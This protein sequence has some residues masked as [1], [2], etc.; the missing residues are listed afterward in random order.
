MKLKLLFL[1]SIVFLFINMIH[2]QNP[3]TAIAKN[4]TVKLDASGN[5]TVNAQDV[6]NG[7]TD[8]TGIASY[9]LTTATVGTRCITA[10]ENS[11]L[12]AAAATGSIFKTVDFAIYG[13]SAK[14]CADASYPSCYSNV[15]SFVSSYFLNNNSASIFISNANM[16]GDPCPNVGKILSISASYEPSPAS[17]KPSF[18]FSC[19]NIGDNTVTLV[20][21]DTDGNKSYATATIKVIDDTAPVITCPANIVTNSDPGICTANVVIPKAG[22]L[23][24]KILLIAA[25]NVSWVA[26]VQNKLI[27]TGAFDSVDFFNAASGTPGTTLLANYKAALVWT[28]NVLNNATLLGNNLATYVDNG[29][30]VVSMVFELSGLGVSGAFNTDAYRCLIA[31]GQLNGRSQSLGTVYNSMHPIMNGVLSFNG[32]TSGYRSSSRTLATGAVKIADWADGTPL[33]IIKENVGLSKVRRADLNFFPPSS[34]SRSDFWTATTDGTILMKNA[35]LWVVGSAN[36]IAS[37]NCSNGI[38]V[39]NNITGTNDASGVYPVGITEV[40]WKATDASGNSVQCTQTVEVKDNQ[41]PVVTS[42]GDQNVNVDANTCG[43]TVTVSA[44]ATDNCSVGNPTGVRSD[45]KLLTDVYPVGTTTIKWN[46]KDVN[47]NDAVELIQAVTV[48]DNEIPVIVSNGDQNVNTDSGICG[49]LVSVSATATDNCAVVTPTGVR[50]DSKLLTDFY[51][52]GS[53]TIT[54]NVS[55]DNGNAAAVVIQTV[56]VTDNELPTVIV[57][58][59]TAQLDA[60]GNATILTSDV[61]NGSSDNCGI[62]KIELDKTSFTCA[63][64]GANTVTLTVTDV[65]GNVS[66]QTAI[67]TIEDK[68]A[69][70]VLTKD[71]TVQLD[72]TG[73]ASIVTSDIDNGST[74]ACGIATLVVS[75]NAFTCANLG[76]NTVTLTATDTNGNISSQTAIVTI[77]DKIAA[78]VLTKDITVQLDATGN[79]SVVTSDIDNGSTDA[80]GIATLVVSPNAFTCANLG[81]NTVTLTATDA[82]GNISSQT[83]IVTIEDK[84]A[85]TVLTK[86][87]T[88]QLDATGNASIVTSDIDNGSTDACGIAI[89]VVSPNAFTCANLG[90]NT[91]T[92]TATDVNGNISSQTAIV[93]IEDKI[94]PTVLTKDITVQLDASGVVTIQAADVDNGS[95]DICGAPTLV[96]S[97][98]TFTCANIGNNTVTLTATD[99]SGNTSSKT[100]IVKVENKILPNVVT[101]NI[102]IQLNASGN[103]SLVATDINNGSTYA[104]GTPTLI[105][106]PNTFTCANIG[107]NIVTLT[108][109]DAYGNVSS[110]TATVIIEDKIAP[111][112][113]AKNITVQ[114]DATGSVTIIPAQVDN[115][116]TDI[117]NAPILSLSKSTFT[118]NNVGANTI[119]LTAIDA[120]GNKSSA[121][122]ILTVQDNILP[123]AKT[124]DLTVE[125]DD[126]GNVSITPNQINNGSSDNCGIAT[127]TLDKLS[128]NCTNVGVNTVILTVKDKAGNTATATAKVTIVN[129]AGDNDNDGILDNCDDDD[130]NDGVKD[131]FDN[132]PITANPY[133]EDRNNNGIGDACDKDQM[134]I[135]QAFTPNGDGI[136]DTWVISNIENHPNSVVRVFNRW[137]TEVFTARNYQ[138]DWDGHYKGNSSSLP[139][140]SSYYY[141][142]DL[143][144][145]GTVDKEGWIYINR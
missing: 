37:D 114:L 50:S 8:N 76:D 26:E 98:S 115:G 109:T 142:I 66:S 103:A 139:E 22:N 65:N 6:D 25:E 122:A 10:N 1:V 111:I 112:V 129:K 24:P 94:A 104:C 107:A 32:G 81:D 33:V 39:T 127:I 125:L 15:Q 80:C 13:T 9:M 64:I 145:N 83:A 14:S 21:T 140:S 19:A 30:G 91:V 48:T 133:Q 78:T 16:G 132:C 72:A 40:I 31:G 144:G 42:N 73:N 45:A 102:T 5:V 118:C 11:T 36:S 29:G 124:Q 116:S 62:D 90:D 84:I 143:D 135:S 41:I 51:P 43:A 70:T 119:T 93:K 86:D 74:D 110:K 68:I 44:S 2:A 100:A 49:A 53:T 101:K 20:V 55:D 77:E 113:L 141:Q 99:A 34:T 79:V 75:P 89:L 126:V 18:T 7:S 38:T 27:A 52:V 123:I 57:K 71:I 63:N 137:G 58:D 121:T 134:N 85:A 59:F 67:V 92:L 117:C 35:L 61:D 131:S 108:A 3:P 120:S 23:K 96:V 87:I 17:L 60:T 106:S 105:V 88:V 95:T 136:N 56:M 97:P 54:W 46:V 69:A 12:L 47:G 4:I 28:D 130:D 82:N 128:F 138:N